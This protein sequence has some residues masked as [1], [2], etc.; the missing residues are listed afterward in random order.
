MAPSTLK[1]VIHTLLSGLT[2]TAGVH[3]EPNFQTARMW[4]E[5][6]QQPRSGEMFMD[7]V[8]CNTL[9]NYTVSRNHA[10]LAALGCHSP[11]ES[12]Y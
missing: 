6:H 3:T 7:I 9:G 5:D 1:E 11:A 8:S 12:L 2:L 4:V 10:G